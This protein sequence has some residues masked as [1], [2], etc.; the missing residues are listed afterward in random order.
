V[1][2]SLFLPSE[3]AAAGEAGPLIFYREYTTLPDPTSGVQAT[4]YDNRDLTGAT[5]IRLEPRIDTDYGTGSPFPNLGPDQFS[6]WW[7]G[8]VLADR[9]ETYRFYTQTDDGTRL[10]VD[11][12]ALVDDWTDHGVV[13]NSG[14]ITLTAGRHDLRM[15]FYDNGGGALARL[16]WSSPSTPKAVVPTDHLSP[17]RTGLRGEYYAGITLAGPAPDPGGRHGEL[18]LG[19]RVRRPER[20]RRTDQRPVDRPGHPHLRPDVPVLHQLRRRVPAVGQQH[21]CWSTTG[22]TRARPNAAAPSP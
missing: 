5:L 7:S 2:V 3:G 18:Q 17:P 20:R 11:G 21:P 12:V 16:L 9:A 13:E 8:R 6:V 14:T 15:Q 10:W 4:Y 1:A 19:H 22:S